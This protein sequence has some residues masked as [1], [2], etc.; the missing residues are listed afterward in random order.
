MNNEI[1]V[2]DPLV[3]FFHWGLVL[4]FVI[5]YL[6]GDEE[7]TLHVYAGYAVLGLITFRIF[8]GLVGTQYA[9]FSNFVA[10]PTTTIDY[11]KNLADKPK[12]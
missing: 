7:S 10:T 3:R 12:R 1:R 6:S 8:W 2:W 11:L 4:T 9:R 5:S